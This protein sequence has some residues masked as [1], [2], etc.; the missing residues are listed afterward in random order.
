MGNCFRPNDKDRDS[1]DFDPIPTLQTSTK[2]RWFK[3]LKTDKIQYF[4]NN[5]LNKKSDHSSFEQIDKDINRTYP[6]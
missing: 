5:Y 2:Q 1:S 4:E 3:L 6:N